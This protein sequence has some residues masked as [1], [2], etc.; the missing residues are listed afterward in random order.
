[1]D[2]FLDCTVNNDDDYD[3]SNGKLYFIV[4]EYTM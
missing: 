2:I 4:C 3:D 1:M